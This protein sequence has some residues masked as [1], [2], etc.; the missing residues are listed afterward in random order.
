MFK[1]TS[2]KKTWEDLICICVLYS[3]LLQ[4]NEIWLP[5]SDIC[6]IEPVDD[7]SQG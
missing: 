4:V 5:T 3:A 1:R 2:Q 6:Y 7:M